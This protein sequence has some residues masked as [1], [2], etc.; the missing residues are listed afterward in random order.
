MHVFE[1]EA[2]NSESPRQTASKRQWRQFSI[3]S[4]L[5]TTTFV[6][7]ILGTFMHGVHTQRQA[8]AEIRKLGFLGPVGYETSWLGLVLPASIEKRHGD[9]FCANVVSVG[10][11]YGTVDRRTVTPTDAELEQVVDAISRL[12]H[13]TQL[14]MHMIDLHNDDVA[15]LAPLRHKIEELYIE[16][17]FRGNLRGN[18]LE[19]LGDWTRLRNLTILSFGWND[20]PNL[21]PLASLPRLTHLSIGRGRLSEKAFADIATIDSLQHVRLFLCDFDGEHL[22]H[23]RKLPHLASLSL[24]NMRAKAEHASYTEDELGNLQPCGKPSFRFE[25]IGREFNDK[26]FFPTEGSKQWLN[27]ILPN[28]EIGE[29]SVMN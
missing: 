3:R 19:H 4:L 12:P 5:L 1:A 15:R 2:G 9:D 29:V 23:L 8:V 21:R 28:V 10:I 27:E 17:G 22:R 14:S 6:A 20:T 16:D 26:D 13:V 18:G 11:H 7:F 24:Q 25:S